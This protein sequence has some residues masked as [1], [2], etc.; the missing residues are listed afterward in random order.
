MLVVLVI[1]GIIVFVLTDKKKNIKDTPKDGD[2]IIKE[3][4]TDD[5]TDELLSE[6]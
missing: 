6:E 2:D 4:Q 5:N 3:V 1:I